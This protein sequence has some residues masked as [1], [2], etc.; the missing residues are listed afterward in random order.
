MAKTLPARK[1]G[2]PHPAE[3]FTAP[4]TMQAGVPLAGLIDRRLIKLLAESMIAVVPGFDAAR[5]T[6]RALRGLGSLALMPRA[7]HVARALAFE[8]PHDADAALPLLIGS[9][10]PE[11]AT[12]GGN[13]LAPFFYLPHSQ[14]I[15]MRPA[16]LECGMWACRE[17]T[18]RFTAEFC[19]RPYLMQYS[20]SALRYLRDW[21]RDPNPHVRRL[22]SEG[23]RPRLPWGLRLK[24]YQLDPSPT[25]ALLELLKDDSEPYV[26]RSVANH[27]GDILKDNPAAAYAVC[28]RWIQEARLKRGNS[29]RAAQRLWIVRHAIRLP[30]KRGE[31]RAVQLRRLAADA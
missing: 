17:L 19:I 30:A 8:L 2:L 15:S 5:F 18:K 24:Q 26:R 12:T 31:R 6:R 9:L 28:E 27:L 20:S 23:S 21:A 10:G 29:E 16:S 1:A 11:L 4:R 25:L 3:R 22:V 14:F 7:A 13:G